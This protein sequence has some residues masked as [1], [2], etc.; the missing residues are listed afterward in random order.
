L[1]DGANALSSFSIVLAVAL[2]ALISWRVS[3][4]L[5][6]SVPEQS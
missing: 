5:R 6:K 1:L 4:V 2:I 3:L